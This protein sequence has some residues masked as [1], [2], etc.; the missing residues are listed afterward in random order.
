MVNYLLIS[1]VANRF[2]MAY[3]KYIYYH[4]SFNMWGGRQKYLNIMSIMIIVTHLQSLFVLF[5]DNIQA[6]NL[7]GPWLTHFGT[8]FTS[9]I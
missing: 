2:E 7:E 3:Y 5:V 8:N 6:I 4:E 9:N 1:V